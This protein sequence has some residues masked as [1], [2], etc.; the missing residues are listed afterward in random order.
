MILYINGNYPHHSL[1]EELVTR[2]ADMGNAI[3]VF[4]PMRGKKLD[5][6]YHSDH[7]DVSVLYE[8]CLKGLDRVFFLQKIYRIVK[9][10]EEQ[11][12]LKNVGC[13]IAGTLYSDGFAAYLLHQKYNIPFSVAVRQTDITYQMRW[14]PYLDGI[15]KRL[16]DHSTNI[17]FLSPTYKRYFDKFNTDQ[18]KYMTIPNAVNEFWFSHRPK[19]RMIHTPISLI[20]VGEVVKN[21]NVGATIA[22][23]AELKKNN[24]EVEFH[25]IGSGDEEKNCRTLS[26]NMN[27]EKQVFFHGW[28]NSKEKLKEFYDR[29]DIFVMPSYR[30]TFGTV[31]VEAMSQGLPL[32][33]TK[34]QGID[35]YFDEGSIGYGCDPTDVHDIANKILLIIDH[36]KEISEQCTIQ[37]D[38]FR[39]NIVADQYNRVINGM[40]RK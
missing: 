7:H 29:A 3:I 31:Y 19:T 10:I 32:I 24:V 33:Y 38:I 17:I 18:A 30:E 2:L 28:Q 39:W 36:Y 21:K 26:K 8:D 35:G 13:I 37:S 20:Y 34:G 5:G 12:D 1:H 27:V 25:I 9:R 11:I 22:S 15:V 14:R 6:K 4:V 40:E 16:L 23:V